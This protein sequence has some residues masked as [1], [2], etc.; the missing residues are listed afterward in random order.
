MARPG[1]SP[2]QIL[3][4]IQQLESTGTEATVTAIRDRLGTG[5]FTTISQVLQSWRHERARTSRPPVPELP[6]S[7]AGLFRQL[8]AESW[9]AADAI[10]AIER[11]AAAQD[12]AAHEAE[13]QEMQNEIGR[14]EQS[15]SSL[16]AETD[17][18]AEDHAETDRALQA[19]RIE[20]AQAAGSVS[21][22][23]DEITQLR[24]SQHH[25]METGQKASAELAVWI[26]R[27]TRA[28]T[29]L[30]EIQKRFSKAKS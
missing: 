12:R 21:L 24:A 8:W 30:E 16:R 20:H 29:R 2:E 15:L 25:V 28:E 13:A 5:S 22:L 27:A 9:R 23:Q 1:I 3:Q 18:L 19:S 11:E 4:T 6:D 17:K 10:G 14:L 7:V 26:E